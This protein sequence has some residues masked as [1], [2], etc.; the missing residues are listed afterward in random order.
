MQ[1]N[2]RQ[3]EAGLLADLAPKGGIR[4]LAETDETAGNT[5]T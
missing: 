1:S 4:L 5:P 2:V 3:I